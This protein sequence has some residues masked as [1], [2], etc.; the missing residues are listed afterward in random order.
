MRNRYVLVADV[1]AVISAAFG[2][3]VLRFD[4]GFLEYRAE[5]SAFLAAALV[6]KPVV[7]YCFGLYGRYW[8]YASVSDLLAVVF[9]CGAAAVTMSLVVSLALPL[10]VIAEFSRAVLV[11]DSLLTL[12]VTA[13]IRMSL[14]AIQEPKARARRESGPFRQP[15]TARRRRVLVVGAGDAGAQRKRAV[16]RVH[17]CVH[18]LLSDVALGK[19]NAFHADPF[20]WASTMPA[21]SNGTRISW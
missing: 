5:F 7:F 1:V 18:R 2:A 10:G 12:L 3:F 21:A 13:G 16:G 8:R 11:I 15:G 9:A 17:D 4:W 14:R 6:I 19:R 20:S